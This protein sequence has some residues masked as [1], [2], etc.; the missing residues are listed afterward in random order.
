MMEVYLAIAIGA[1]NLVIMI[2]LS[3]KAARESREMEALKFIQLVIITELNATIKQQRNHSIGLKTLG[4]DC[5]PT[6]SATGS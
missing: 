2:R 1:A 6:D 5:E 4:A 3:L